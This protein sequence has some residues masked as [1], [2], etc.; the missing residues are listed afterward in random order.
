[1]ANHEVILQELRDFRR[2]NKDQ[3]ENISGELTKVNAR[4]EEAEERVERVEERMLNVEETTSELV[5]LYM[6]LE[7]NTMNMESQSRRKNI[8][9]YGVPE[10]SEKDAPSMCAFV[11]VLL[12]D[13]LKLDGLEINI[14][15]A[16]R[17][18]GPLP[19]KEAPA[20][21]IVVKFLSFRIK[22]QILREAWQKRGFTWNENR[23]KLD[24][25]YPPL[26]L[27]KRRDYAEVRKKLKENQIH[28][29]TLYPA[30]LKVNFEDGEKIYNTALEAI[31]DMSKRG[32]A[33]KMTKPPE[34]IQ[35]QLK[36]L[37]WTRVTRNGGSNT[38]NLGQS[39]KE[40]LR[41]FKRSTTTT[42]S[43]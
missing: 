7:E 40:K 17:S 11:E 15:R 10:L 32:Y 5:Q 31:E 30:R 24:N 2:E 38:A 41:A 3:L 13:G 36:Q 19:P 1:M 18:L 22:E 4:L 12:R 28:F 39:Y 25:D 6:K 23:I 37:S 43:N 27:K 21:S 29:K 33:L 42:S 35:E 14:E 20:R 9:I 16:H 34:S 8:R 26:I